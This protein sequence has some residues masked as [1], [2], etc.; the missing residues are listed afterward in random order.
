MAGLQQAKYPWKEVLRINND[1]LINRLDAFIIAI[2]LHSQSIITDSDKQNI[3]SISKELTIERN[4]KLIDILKTKDEKAFKAFI[5]ILN[6]KDV[7]QKD[8]A[9]ELHDQTQWTPEPP[10]PYP[11]S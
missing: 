7:L 2:K 8:L 10:P 1:R 6:S 3:F 5:L 11:S 4:A 9:Q